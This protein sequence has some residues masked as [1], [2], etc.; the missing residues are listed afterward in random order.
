MIKNM[1]FYDRAIRAIV[2]IV[3]IWLI[4]V[5]VTSGALFMVLILVAVAMAG[6]SLMGTCP[7]YLPFGLDTH[8][9]KK[10]T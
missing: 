1:G 4:S 8:F 5:D 2:A 6:T 10:K 3:L 7:L 9:K